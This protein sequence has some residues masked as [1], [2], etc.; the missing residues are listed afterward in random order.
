MD[1]GRAGLDHWLD[2]R[3]HADAR[4]SGAR[5]QDRLSGPDV[6]SG[7]VKDLGNPL[8]ELTERDE[9]VFMNLIEDI[10]AQF[11]DVTAERRNLS[12]DVVEKLADGQIFSGMRARNENL[13]DELGGLH[14]SARRVV[15]LAKARS[16]ELQSDTSTTSVDTV[17]DPALVYP[18]SP[19]PEFIQ[20]LTESVGESIGRAIT[21]TWLQ[22]LGVDR[23]DVPVMVR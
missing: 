13:V 23:P 15:I 4:P 1:R 5:G 12:R 21:A 3:Y 9:E 19:T 18:R 16:G 8:R 17:D 7:P 14:H 11:V 2:R 6:Q 10:Y 20:L 22:D